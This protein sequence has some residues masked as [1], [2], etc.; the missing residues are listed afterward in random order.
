M[1][2]RSLRGSTPVKVTAF[3]MAIIFFA[4]AVVSFMGVWFCAESNVYRMSKEAFMKNTLTDVANGYARGVAEDYISLGEDYIYGKYPEGGTYGSPS[5]NFFFDIKDEDGELLATTNKGEA[6]RFAVSYEYNYYD[7][8][9]SGGVLDENGLYFEYHH[10]GEKINK[11]ITVE[12]Y[13]KQEFTDADNFYWA[14]IFVNIIYALRYWAIFACLFSVVA[15]IVLFVFLMCSAGHRNG[16][17]II[18]RSFFDKI[19]FD[20]LTAALILCAI[21]QVFLFYEYLKAVAFVM[22][23]GIVAVL[24]LLYL[25]S[26]AVRIKTKTLVKNNLTV[27]ICLAIWH[28]LKTVAGAVPFI[29]KILVFLAIYCV[30]GFLWIAFFKNNIDMQLLGWT[31]PTLV[32]VVAVCYSVY[33]MK[34]LKDGAC[35]IAGGKLSH[36]VDTSYMIGDFKAHGE[37]LNNIS[38]GLSFA[39]DERMKSERMK[40]EPITNVSHDI[41]TPLTS[42]INYVDLIKKEDFENEKAREYVEILDRQSQRLKKLICDLVDA[43]KA[44]SGAIGVT[45]EKLDAGVLLE[46]IVGEYTDK[47]NL[48]FV[49]SNPEEEVFIWGDRHHVWRILDNLMNNICKYAMDNTRVYLSIEKIGNNVQIIFKNISAV[50][51]NIS[52]DELMERFVRGDSSRNTEGSGL[53]LSIAKSL[54]E[55]Q[56]GRLQLSVDGDLFKSVLTFDAV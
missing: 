36:K 11:C 49:L 34:K 20:I 56:G 35:E 26:L 51:L 10:D 50:P 33:C 38:E 17:D 52:S 12:L 18:V 41:K 7:Y 54:A 19:P 55:L 15:F 47:A 5:R 9:I 1:K 40:T 32:F 8:D 45:M 39:V 44:S 43:S 23:A 22:F 4:V 25:M 31:V 30:S 37:T 16:K 46:Q 42:I 29:W 13:V 48:S 53:G 28:L 21:I 2:K 27:K 6:S 24:G 14:E 3:I